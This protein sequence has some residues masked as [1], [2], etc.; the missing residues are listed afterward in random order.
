MV[1]GANKT[2]TVDGQTAVIPALPTSARSGDTISLTMRPEA[3]SL[4]NGHA[5]DIVLDGVV[6]EVSFLGSVIRLRVKLGENDISLDTFNDQRTPPPLQGDN[7]KVTLA[8]SDV[9][10]LN[11]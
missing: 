9:L 7:V 4:A 10:V 11:D 8:G 6:S 2:V 1:D 3:I 5:R